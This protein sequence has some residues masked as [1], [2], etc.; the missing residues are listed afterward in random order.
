MAG[1][2]ELFERSVLLFALPTEIS[3]RGQAYAPRAT[4]SPVR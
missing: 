3:S 1:Y 2:F 4:D